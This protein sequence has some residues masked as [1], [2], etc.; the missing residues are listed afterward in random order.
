L[1]QWEQVCKYLRDAPAAPTDP[2]GR[3][4]LKR[5]LD[6]LA[7]RDGGRG[8]RELLRELKDL[9][10]QLT[11][12]SWE[13]IRLRALAGKVIDRL[14][15]P[16]S[17]TRLTHG[18]RV[19]VSQA[20]LGYDPDHVHAHVVKAWSH[21]FLRQYEDGFGE[22]VHVDDG[23]CTESDLARVQ[24]LRGLR[25]VQADDQQRA[26]RAHA[27]ERLRRR[28]PGVAPPD[29]RLTLCLAYAQYGWSDFD[30]RADVLHTLHT[31]LSAGDERER[32]ALQGKYGE[33][34]RA[35]ADGEVERAARL[36]AP[37]QS[38]R[39]VRLLEQARRRVPDDM[40]AGLQAGHDFFQTLD[41]YEH[42]PAH[43]ARTAAAV[44]FDLYRQGR[45][46]HLPD[47]AHGLAATALEDGA[48]SLEW[49]PLR[50]PFEPLFAGPQDADRARDWLGQADELR[51]RVGSSRGLLPRLRYILALAGGTGPDRAALA[52]LLAEVKPD[53]AALRQAGRAAF[54]VL[55][56]KAETQG[57]APERDTRRQG[58]AT[59]ESLWRL[60][61][62]QL[63]DTKDELALAA[64]QHVLRSAVRLGEALVQEAADRP[65]RWQ[66]ARLCA[67][68][69]ALIARFPHAGWPFAHDDAQVFQE[70]VACYD[71]AIPRHREDDVTRAD[72]Y[73][74]RGLARSMTGGY[75][76]HRAQMLKD[77]DLA[78]KLAE[79]KSAPG[80]ALRGY[81][82]Y[83][84]A[85]RSPAGEKQTALLREA[86]D[87]LGQAI[88]L[89]PEGRDWLKDV[90]DFCSYRSVVLVQLA[91]ADVGHRAARLRA[92]EHE[93]EAAVQASQGERRQEALCA[94]GIAREAMAYLAGVT[95]KYGG[96]AAAFQEAARL[97][98]PCPKAWIGLG[99]CEYRRV[100]YGGA[101]PAYLES[102]ARAVDKVL[103]ERSLADRLT[104]V[105]KA[106]AL[107]WHAEVAA[108]RGDAAAAEADLGRITDVLAK[109]KDGRLVRGWAD[110]R[111]CLLLRARIALD[112]ARHA[113]PGKDRDEMLKR[114][115]DV[116]RRLQEPGP[117]PRARAAD[118][119]WVIGQV[120][121]L[122]SADQPEDALHAYDVGLKAC[123]DHHDEH[124]LRVKLARLELLA[125]DGG[126]V[127]KLRPAWQAFLREAESAITAAQSPRVQDTRL[128]ARAYH[129]AY[130]AH[131]AAAGEPD[132]DAVLHAHHTHGLK[133]LEQ[134]IRLI[135]PVHAD[136]ARWRLD[137]MDEL[138][139]LM[140]S[141][142]TKPAQRQV[143]HARARRL[144]SEAEASP[145]IKA[146][147]A[148]L[149]ALK[150]RL[151]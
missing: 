37:G 6:V 10:E 24:V 93:A 79:R 137:A 106:E 140:S 135:P 89:L 98:G 55:C 131:R 112:K 7:D 25:C 11:A 53:R 132:P 138:L 119:A 103:H 86:A 77:A 63:D 90:A 57:Q 39:C 58:L 102:A 23:A 100:A 16:A 67:A 145:H 85:R 2:A 109:G 129:A 141:P 47:K 147:A 122:R 56:L 4:Y 43:H 64:D 104:A 8:G 127:A 20:V 97:A 143:Y 111:R 73:A 110:Y 52:A 50:H 60:V 134:A 38:G 94:L 144:L 61:S 115:E 78:L 66:V 74:R 148:R 133:H 28:I 51:K 72:F 59:Y 123:G 84:D 13:G 65:L 5:A 107:Y 88:K 31:V 125:G 33:L 130:R 22:L 34:A 45:L 70:V 136:A 95:Q 150:D 42:D 142:Q 81:L 35:Y 18:E 151:R 99:R 117:D 96:A 120:H 49:P 19:R 75:A 69:A 36:F 80:H 26:R 41:D 40:P 126:Q 14:L 118:A 44:L 121:E 29:D 101:D 139:W 30:H 48:A 12:D 32:S 17:L 146:E 46:P 114:A 105:L 15:G 9:R 116:A 113:G 149:A 71:E 128:R 68:R 124:F 27:H 54:Q 83:E 92:A 62:E 76:A 21:Y 82:D 108:L 3:A 87:E 1:G 91:F